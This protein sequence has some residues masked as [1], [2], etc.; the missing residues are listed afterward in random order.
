MRRSL[1]EPSAVRAWLVAH[2]AQAVGAAM[3]LVAVVLAVGAQWLLP[4][5][6]QARKVPFWQLTPGFLAMLASLATVN[7]LPAGHAAPQRLARGV[8]VGGVL[9][10]AAGCAWIVGLGADLPSLVPGTTVTVALTFAV[11]T[12]LGRISAWV[13]VVVVVV[14][15]ARVTTMAADEDL[16]ASLPVTVRLVLALVAA[17][18]V[19]GYALVG[20]DGV[21]TSRNGGAT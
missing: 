1:R 16:W 15:L 10:L 2:D 11:A 13:G 12:V 20:A 14:V 8:W 4:V 21:T 3:V 7:R 5:P 19:A 17:V 18:G 9:A 6:G